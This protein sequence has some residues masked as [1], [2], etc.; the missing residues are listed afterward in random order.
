MTLQEDGNI[1]LF[2]DG[3]ISILRLDGTQHEVGTGYCPGNDRF[4]DVIADGEGRVFAGTVGENGQLLLFE[5]DGSV[6]KLL[7]GLG[8][9]NG[10]GFTPDNKGM[11]LTDS[12]QRQIYLFDYD[13]KTGALANRRTFIDIPKEIGAP[14]GMTVDAEGFVWT[15]LWFGG[16]VRRYAPDGRLDKEVC[17][18]VKQPSAI[19]FGGAD[20][21]NIYVTTASSTTADWMMPPRFDIN[22]TR[23]GGLY[24]FRIK[25]IEGRPLFRSRIHF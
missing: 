6:T 23:G 24:G 17:L 25:G 4:N 16:R 15:S 14:D 1:L 8:C 3:R 13:H 12:V 7:D 2:Q 20:L 18:P 9:P 5:R 11:Y 22:A 19:V 21:K 10:M